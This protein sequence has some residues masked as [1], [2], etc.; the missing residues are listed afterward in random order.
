[1]ATTK[2]PSMPARSTLPM[3]NNGGRLS[4]LLIALAAL[5]IVALASV[6]TTW[7]ITS[8]MYGAN[9]PQAAQ[10]ATG[11][12][13]QVMSIAPMPPQVVPAPIFIDLE[14]FTVTLQNR[15]NERIVHVGLT[16]RVANEQSRE[17]IQRYMPEVRSRVL[18]VLSAQ[19]PDTVHTAEG[20]VNLASAIA[21]E[22]NRP[23]SPLPDGQY[24]TDVLFTA[25]VVQ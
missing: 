3:R 6:A 8:R 24:V 23:F 4:R 17:R 25:F 15:D 12:P 13:P 22:V 21:H 10:A 11:Q 1:M 9:A 14:P 5:L 19:N 16:L 7:I 18:M 2:N 20:K